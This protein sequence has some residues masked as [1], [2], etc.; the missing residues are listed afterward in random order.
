MLQPNE[1]PCGNDAQKGP[2]I[3]N[4]TLHHCSPT[5]ALHDI[6]AQN[7]QDLGITSA[8]QLEKDIKSSDSKIWMR[9]RHIHA[10]FRR[11]VGNQ[12]ADET[13]TSF[14]Q[15]QGIINFNCERTKP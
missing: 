11:E 4:Y 12:V 7:A 10:R 13:G 6:C 5:C 15:T 8:S 3:S 9:A 2:D 14:P 1:V